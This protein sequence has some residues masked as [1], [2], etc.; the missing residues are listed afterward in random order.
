MPT[1]A[2]RKA[3]AKYDAANTKTYA[4]KLNRNTDADIISKLESEENVQGYIKGLIREDI[5]EG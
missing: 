5:K 3:S 1:E 2:Q 4:V